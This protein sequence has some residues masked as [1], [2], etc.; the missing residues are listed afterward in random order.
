VSDAHLVHQLFTER[1]T[2]ARELARA[3]DRWAELAEL[4]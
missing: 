2:L 3:L 4:A 1:E